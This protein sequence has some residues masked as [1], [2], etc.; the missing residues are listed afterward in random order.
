M[1]DKLGSLPC[2]ILCLHANQRTFSGDEFLNRCCSAS[3]ERIVTSASEQRRSFL[4]QLHARC[5]CSSSPEELQ[6]QLLRPFSTPPL[7]CRSNCS[8]LF[9]GCNCSCSP[10]QLR[11]A[12]QT[13]VAAVPKNCSCYKLQLQL[14]Q[15]CSYPGLSPTRIESASETAAGAQDDGLQLQF[16]RRFI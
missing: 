15:S 2:L 8:Q 5:S 1:T 14:S 6:L 7:N 11:S 10:L 12:S 16:H 9:P 3:A 13:A 4:L